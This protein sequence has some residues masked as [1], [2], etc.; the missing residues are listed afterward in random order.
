MN[1]EQKAQ[2]YDWLLDQYKQIER[3]ISRIPKLPLDETLQDL[4]SKEYSDANQIQVTNLTNKLR[5]IDE[6][7]KRLF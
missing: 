1:Q 2:R 4:N 5:M 7:V 3:E 6:E